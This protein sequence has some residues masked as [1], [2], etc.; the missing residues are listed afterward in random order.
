MCRR[1]AM[2]LVFAF[3][4]MHVDGQSVQNQ[5]GPVSDTQSWDEVDVFT[6]LEPKL[7]V[8]WIARSRLSEQLSNP[9][10]TGFESDWRIEMMKNLAV[11]PSFEYFLFRSNAGQLEHGEDPILELTPSWAH[12]RISLSDRNRFCGRFGTDGI[13]PSWDY[14]NRA[15]IDYRLGPSRWNVSAFAWDEAFYYSKYA[16]WTRNRVAIGARKMMGERVA[17]NLYFQWESNQIGEPAH[18]STIALLME[19]RIR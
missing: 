1:S 3:M 2:I 8:T 19:V 5:L 12:Q 6:R 4:S 11:T 15:R 10:I 18:I 16:G 9:V 7:D 13:G 14:R 17:G